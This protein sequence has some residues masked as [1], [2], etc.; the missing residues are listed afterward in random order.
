MT[1]NIF[2]CVLF[3]F[4]CHPLFTVYSQHLLKGRSVPSSLQEYDLAI[5]NIM[6]FCE[7]PVI[8]LEN[9]KDLLCAYLMLINVSLD[10]SIFLCSYSTYQFAIP[11]PTVCSVFLLVLKTFKKSSSERVPSE[12]SKSPIYCRYIS[13][14]YIYR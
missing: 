6:T 9:L 3:P 12:C 4:N 5:D 13:K 10:A 8:S 7:E 14:R 1:I 2:V 11:G